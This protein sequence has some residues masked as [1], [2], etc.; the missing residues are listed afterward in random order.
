MDIDMHMRVAGKVRM[1]IIII[2]RRLSENGNHYQKCKD[3]RKCAY[4]PKSAIYRLLPS[5]KFFVPNT[6]SSQELIPT[7]SK[8]PIPFSRKN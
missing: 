8:P 4:Q 2:V 6:I 3:M 1:G 7:F 5:S